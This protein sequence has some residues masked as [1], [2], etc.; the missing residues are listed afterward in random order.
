MGAYPLCCCARWDGF[1]EDMA[2]LPEDLVTLS[3]VTDP[4]GNWTPDLLHDTFQDVVHPYKEHVVI[5]PRNVSPSAHHRRNIRRSLQQVDV[6]LVASPA[7]FTP[8]WQDLY[9]ELVQRHEISGIPAFSTRSFQDQLEVPGIVV[10]RGDVAG[11]LAGAIL[12]YQDQDRAYYHLGAYSEK[13]YASLASYA[14]FDAAIT[15]F[16]AAG[17]DRFSIGAGAGVRNDGTDG[18]TRFKRGWSKE[19]RT[20][21]F[22]GR[23]LNTKA[24]SKLTGGRSG[25]SF[26]PSY[27]SPSPAVP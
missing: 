9:D 16:A 4:F 1:A 27:R 15:H 3:L 20:V 25:T 14:L 21:F 10:F 17:V 22:C 7:T 2:D 18:L 13:G 24:Y 6:T 8:Q 5:D 12:C 11:E 19:T 23:V 26:F